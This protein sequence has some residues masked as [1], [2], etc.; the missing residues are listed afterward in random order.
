MK[1]N[2]FAILHTLATGQFLVD[3]TYEHDSDEFKLSVK[4]WS[5][6][7]NGYVT[8]TL[9]WTGNDEADFI[10]TFDMFRTVEYCENWVKAMNN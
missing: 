4:F 10:K 6:N 7:V 9:S 2:E 8:M 3:T 5:S 1:N